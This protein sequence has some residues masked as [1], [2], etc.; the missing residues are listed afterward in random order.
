MKILYN[1]VMLADSITDKPKHIQFT[2]HI[3]MWLEGCAS[4]KEILS[5]H[6][7]THQRFS[8]AVWVPLVGIF[9]M[10]SPSF[11]DLSKR[12]HAKK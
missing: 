8:I 5:F 2:S 1:L 3:G 11:F 7:V 12:V 9:S 6:F 4:I 10:V